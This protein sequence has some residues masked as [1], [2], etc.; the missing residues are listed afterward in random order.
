MNAK[1]DKTLVQEALR[2]HGRFRLKARGGSMMPAI[3][4]AAVLEI[5][6]AQ[7]RNV[8]F[9]DVVMA[10]HQ[11]DFYLIHRIVRKDTRISMIWTKGDSLDALDPPA[12]PES[13]LGKVVWFTYRGKRVR[14][15]RGVM[16][17]AGPLVAALSFFSFFL[18]SQFS[19]LF[20]PP[21]VD[22]PLPRFVARCT[23]VP[24][25]LMAA[26]LVFLS[27]LLAESPRNSDPNTGRNDDRLL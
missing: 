24:G 6:P 3:P 26:M 20:T 13:L 27:S 5:E 11:D 21:S 7:L 14:L 22:T 16:L 25:W 9:G 10:V 1:V 23:R 2:L 8:R 15:D 19:K 17:W 4:D 18:S 12:G